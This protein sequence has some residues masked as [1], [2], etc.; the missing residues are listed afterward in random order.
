[1]QRFKEYIASVVIQSGEKEEDQKD[2][3]GSGV[4][5]EIGRELTSFVNQDIVDSLMNLERKRSPLVEK[6]EKENDDDDENEKRICLDEI[7]SDG[8]GFELFS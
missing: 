8:E 5:N 4:L 3:F 7:D 1:M 2:E 6:Q